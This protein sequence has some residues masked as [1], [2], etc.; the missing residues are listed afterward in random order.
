MP[1][2]A[3][4]ETKLVICVWHSFTL[5]RPPADVAVHVRRRYPEMRVVHL[6]TYDHLEE[7]IADTD[8]F[9]GFSLR[10][11]QFSRAAKLK[12]IHSTAA[13]VG[14]LMFP[15]LRASGVVVTNASGVHTIPMAE[16]ILGM[17]VALARRFPSAVRYQ[18]QRRWAQQEIWDEQLRPRELCGQSLLLV[19]FGAIGKEVAKRVRPLGMRIWAVTRSGRADT[20]LAER[21]LP[22]ARLE[23]VLHEAD[24]VILA[25]P[26][27]PETRHLIG[28]RQLAAM[29]PSAY[30]INVARGSL[31]DEAA[32]IETLRKRAIAGAALDVAE[33][34][35]LP[36]ES[37]FWTLPN[38][39]VTPHISAVSE[40]LWDRQTELLL[41]NLA[42]WFAGR[43]L[44]NRVD[45]ARGY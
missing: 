5:W 23:E 17:L 12:W 29:K 28:A 15:E 9:V 34:E 33:Q 20:D 8:I 30:L 13:G 37:P 41:E 3:P 2:P 22:A 7:E 1:R 27:T 11:Q 38:V 39:F 21:V 36:P 40:Y 43:E 19:G 16:H 44:L 26:E 45:L 25:A 31:V 18:M 4:G 42:R 35:P 14:Q 24:F 32:L 6:T 10:P